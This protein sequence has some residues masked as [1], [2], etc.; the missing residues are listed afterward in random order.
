MEQ[1]YDGAK[2]L[3]VQIPGQSKYRQGERRTSDN[4][5]IK[6]NEV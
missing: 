1:F 4:C 3:L 5:C 6:S 2:Q